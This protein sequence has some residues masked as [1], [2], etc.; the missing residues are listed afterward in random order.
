MITKTRFQFLVSWCV[1]HQMVTS[2]VGR[3]VV[4]VRQTLVLLDSV[5]VVL[6]DVGVLSGLVP[7]K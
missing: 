6:G 2:F 4:S 1:C 3:V 5:V 7:C